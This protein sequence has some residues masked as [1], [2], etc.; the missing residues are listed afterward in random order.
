MMS[1]TPVSG[2][3]PRATIDRRHGP[4][5][6][7]NA[8]HAH[9]TIARHDQWLTMQGSPWYND[10]EGRSRPTVVRPSNWHSPRFSEQ[11]ALIGSVPPRP[12]GTSATKP[13]PISC[14]ARPST[15]VWAGPTNTY[16]SVYVATLLGTGHSCVTHHGLTITLSAFRS[17]MAW[18]PSG[19][20]SRLTVR[21]KTLPG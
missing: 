1:A 14:W 10:L 12:T 20:S 5:S 3:D 15:F 2:G 9:G 7:V 19:T 11:T 6:T 16:S 8:E 17:S 13:I 4:G 18:Y 21:S